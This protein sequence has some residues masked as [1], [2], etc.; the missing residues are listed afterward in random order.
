M[1][2]CERICYQSGMNRYT[3]RVQ[4]CPEYDEY[5][6]TCIEIPYLTGR[7]PTGQEAIAAIE[8]AVDQRLTALRG[9]G[10]DVPTPLSE[11][12]Y[13]GTL[14]IRTSPVLHARLAIEAAEQRVSMNHWVVQKLAD[15]QLGG[16]LGAFPFD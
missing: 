10:E 14:V 3:Y 6:G 2:Y 15:R 7:A 12:S 9:C 16:S 5:L 13:S 11:R 4:W 1:P 8:D